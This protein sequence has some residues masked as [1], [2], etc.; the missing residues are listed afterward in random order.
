MRSWLFMK[1]YHQLICIVAV[2]V[3]LYDVTGCSLE[4]DFRAGVRVG[5]GICA[6]KGV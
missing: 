3:V 4:T 1:G 6:D 5:V 2:I